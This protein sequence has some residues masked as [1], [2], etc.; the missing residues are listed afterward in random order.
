MKNIFLTP[1]LIILTF[2]CKPKHQENV[3]NSKLIIDTSK[4]L[5]NNKLRCINDSVCIIYEKH[6]FLK[7]K[8]DRFSPPN[9]IVDSLSIKFA[10]EDLYSNIDL[11]FDPI[12]YRMFPKKNN[13][14]YF[15]NFY[16]VGSFKD[17]EILTY[18]IGKVANDSIFIVGSK[19]KFDSLKIINPISYFAK[20]EIIIKIEDN[21]KK[22]KFFID[23]N[24]DL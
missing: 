20:F 6:I 17:H 12:L 19:Y 13:D 21:Q 5:I 2:C 18:K 14:N 11:V 24:S 15:I 4:P 10:N 9:N 7:E 22:Y 23:G 1:I 16:K 8:R 3:N